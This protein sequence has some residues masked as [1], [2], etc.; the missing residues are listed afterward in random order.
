MRGIPTRCARDTIV[1]RFNARAAYRA[2]LGIDERQRG[3]VEKT[4]VMNRGRQDGFSNAKGRK[5][6]PKG[7]RRKNFALLCGGLC[8]LC[9]NLHDR[10]T[11]SA[12][13]G[14][15]PRIRS[16]LASAR[17]RPRWRYERG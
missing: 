5:G 15:L 16:E 4:Q 13:V 7:T 2:G 10:Q 14:L 3:V 8:V 17:S 12:T 11:P 6:F 1:A 9:V